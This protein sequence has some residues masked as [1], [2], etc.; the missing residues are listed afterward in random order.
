MIRAIR[1]NRGSVDLEHEADRALVCTRRDEVGP[2]E[3]G[4]EVV[5]RYFVCS[6]K[7]REFQRHA[8]RAV[9]PLEQIIRPEADVEQVSRRDSPWIRIVVCSVF[10]GKSKALGCEAA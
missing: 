8:A 9:L 4:E 2:A 1:V 3:S 10:I 5:K 6:V 7:N